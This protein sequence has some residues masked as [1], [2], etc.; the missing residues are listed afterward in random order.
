MRLLAGTP[1]DRPPTCDRCGQP[2][3]A[4]RCPPILLPKSAVRPDKKADKKTVKLAIEKRKKGKVVTV[5]RGLAAGTDDVV[6]LLSKL[7]NQCGAG[8]TLDGDVLEIQGNHLD[9][10]RTLLDEAGYTVRG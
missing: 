2:E 5:I 1:Y 10:L 6:A 9:R 4:C 8:G 7:K 3:S